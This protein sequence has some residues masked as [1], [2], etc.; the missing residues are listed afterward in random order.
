M[1]GLFR[2]T[3]VPKPL[4]SDEGG[5]A[6][7]SK[8][9][10]R[11]VLRTYPDQIR[12][13]IATVYGHGSGYSKH[14]AY[15]DAVNSIVR[16]YGQYNY[17]NIVVVRRK[18]RNHPMILPIAQFLSRSNSPLVPEWLFEMGIGEYYSYTLEAD[19]YK[20]E[21]FIDDIIAGR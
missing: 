8:R 17:A 3:P 13:P 2:K 11:S 12:G 7:M 4:P 14:E 6:V 1:C 19:L 10:F 15:M 21:Y 18:R 9:E 5:V 20:T 16:N